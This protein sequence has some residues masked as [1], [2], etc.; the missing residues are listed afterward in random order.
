VQATASENH[1]ICPYCARP[2]SAVEKVSRD[3]VVGRGFGGTATIA[4]CKRCKDALGLGIES[5]LLGAGSALTIIASA[6]GYAFGKV[7]SYATDGLA[8]TSDFRENRFSLRVPRRDVTEGSP[9]HLQV[10]LTVPTHID[11]ESL[12]QSVAKQY[13]GTVNSVHRQLLRWKSSRPAFL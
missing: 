8:V 11:S 1:S 5:R 9:G 3:H 12:I 4:A 7:R 2:L 6:A 10:Q 13:R